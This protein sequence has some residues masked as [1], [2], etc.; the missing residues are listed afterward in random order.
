M[1]SPDHISVCGDQ[2]LTPPPL[3]VL[4]LNLR[5]LPNTKTHQN[6]VSTEIFLCLFLGLSQY[7]NEQNL[8][9]IVI[10][11][12]MLSSRVKLKFHENK[13]KNSKVT[14]VYIHTLMYIFMNCYKGQGSS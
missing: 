3:V 2:N 7:K 8:T 9:K 6:E 5:T 14:D 10:H 4:S 12:Q 11:S 1:S 13:N